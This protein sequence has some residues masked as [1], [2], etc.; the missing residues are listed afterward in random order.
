MDR[1][2]DPNRGQFSCAKQPR[3]GHRIASVGLDP[4]S[5]LLGNQRRRHH[6]ALVTQRYNLP[7]EPI[8]R[9]SSF[10]ADPYLLILACQL[11][12]HPLNRRRCAIDLAEIPYL[13]ITTGIGNGNCVLLLCR[14]NPDENFAILSPGSAPRALRLCSARPSNPRAHYGTSGRAVSPRST[15]DITSRPVSA[16][17]SSPFTSFPD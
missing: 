5:R 11:L 9:W 15:T 7:I 6:S 13:P 16:N 17:W 2:R 4:V 1:V 3:Q 10:V 14:I 12:D 8:T